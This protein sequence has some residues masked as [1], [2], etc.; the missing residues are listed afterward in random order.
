MYISNF[1]EKNK[2]TNRKHI[3]FFW[4]LTERPNEIF[5]ITG[6][7]SKLKDTDIAFKMS[8]NLSSLR[9][10]WMKRYRIS[11]ILIAISERKNAWIN[12]LHALATGKPVLN[13][14]TD[15]KKILNIHT[16]IPAPSGTVIFH[17]QFRL[18]S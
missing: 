2:Q 12:T 11:L 13:A 8:V 4:L 1:R 9:T 18:L 7:F 5:W 14:I 16:W 15:N 17:T 10:V 3:Y 6:D